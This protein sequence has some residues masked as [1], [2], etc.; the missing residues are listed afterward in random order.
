V[1]FGADT[2]VA[3]LVDEQGAKPLPAMSKAELADALWT[4]VRE[5]LEAVR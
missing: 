4:H 3:M 5:R 2:N 1:A